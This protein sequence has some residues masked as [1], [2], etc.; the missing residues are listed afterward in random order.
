MKAARILRDKLASNAVV[1]G[2]LCTFHFWPELVE[3]AA[4]AGLDY[5]F[6]DLEHFTHSHETVATGCTLARVMDFPLLIRPPV[7][8]AMHVRHAMDLGA[9][10]LLVP[11]VETVADMQAVQD[12]AYLPPRGKRR[13]GG[14]GCGWVTG[15]N[16]ENWKAEVEDDL[17]VIPQIESKAGL[18]NVDAIAAH[19]LT[20]AIAAGPYDLSADL[21]VCWNPAAPALVTAINRIREAGAK[22]GK[23]M[24]R[25]GD[26]ASIAADGDTFLCVGEPIMAM[27]AAM[28]NAKQ[29][30][31][32]KGAAHGAGD[33]LP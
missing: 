11:T 10:G 25:I 8:D 9:C 27:Q 33:P 26:P 29:A 17:I 7:A 30:A 15:F 13:P 24:W 23:K 4:K 31:L 14:P 5:L 32:G 18:S 21:G 28:A 22:V 3:H 12:G 1:T 20:T 16:Y 6:V 2:M 19:P